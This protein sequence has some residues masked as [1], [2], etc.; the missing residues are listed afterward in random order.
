MIVKQIL[1]GSMANFTYI[2]IDEKSKLAAV[3]DPSWDLENVLNMLKINNL[4][5]KYIIN[6]HTHFDHVLGNE[7][8]VTLTGAETIMHKNSQLDK[9]IIVNDNDVIKLGNLNIKVIYTPGHSKDGIC[10]FV[11]NKLFCGDTLFVG[12]CGRID[13]P[14]GS[15]SE[16]YDSLFD[17][18]IKLDDDI[19]IY[20]GHDYGNKPVS[21]IGDEKKNN[22]VLKPRTKEEFLFFMG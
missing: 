2:I 17:I 16:L 3:V 8:L 9:N 19:E 10:L 5:L 18:L 15:T 7:Q 1:V 6:T 14:G 20:P 22:P 12:S 21:T 13:L 4:K 11:E